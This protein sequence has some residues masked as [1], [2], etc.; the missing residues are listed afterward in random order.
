[1]SS[2]WIAHDTP[3]PIKIHADF[4]DPLNPKVLTEEASVAL[5]GQ[6]L[7]PNVFAG[8]TFWRRPSWSLATL[9]TANSYKELPDGSQRFDVTK[10]AQAR[11]RCLLV[12][13]DLKDDDPSL[14]LEK[15]KPPEAPTVE[16]L[17]DNALRTIGRIDTALFEAFYDRA[18]TKVY[19]RIE[20]R[21]ARE[22][23]SVS[24]VPPTEGESEAGN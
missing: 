11:V 24:I 21:G 7:P 1:M 22:D 17:S 13:W 20:S 4:T 16:M 2:R 8:T 9:I 15:V 23:L 5:D 6:E 19:P 3:V 12:D 18:M 14:A 10:W